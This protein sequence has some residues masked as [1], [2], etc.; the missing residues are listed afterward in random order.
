[1]GQIDINPNLCARR[2][3]VGYWGCKSFGVG[4]MP[5]KAPR[6]EGLAVNDPNRADHR[7]CAGLYD[8]DLAPNIGG[9]RPVLTAFIS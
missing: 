3:V 4:Q 5:A 2:V 9:A 7:F 6:F 8:S 1:M